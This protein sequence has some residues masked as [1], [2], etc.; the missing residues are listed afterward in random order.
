MISFSHRL[1]AALKIDKQSDQ[2]KGI[3]YSSFASWKVSFVD[4]VIRHR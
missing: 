4:A 2:N 3:P 1:A